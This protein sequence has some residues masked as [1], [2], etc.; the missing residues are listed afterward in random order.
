MC[1]SRRTKFHLRYLGILKTIVGSPK[2]AS[3]G[4]HVLPGK[5]CLLDAPRLGNADTGG[6][7]R[8]PADREA[9]HGRDPGEEIET[10]LAAWHG[11]PRL[12][13]TAPE[14]SGA[15][16]V[17]G[18]V[19]ARQR[20]RPCRHG[21]IIGPAAAGNWDSL[22]RWAGVFW[23][24]GRRCKADFRTYHDGQA[25]RCQTLGFRGTRG[26]IADR[27][28]SSSDQDRI[29]D[30]PQRENPVVFGC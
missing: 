2:I 9:F 20:S 11:S 7:A 28:L 25:T 13:T 3:P 15:V 4:R 5:A 18:P 17:S 12:T 19:E 27:R 16:F 30:W 26:V 24:D 6:A 29:L 22:A 21:P 23:R 1:H 14:Q 8:R 10:G